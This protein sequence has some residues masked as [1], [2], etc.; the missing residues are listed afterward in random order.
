MNYKSRTK[1]ARFSFCNTHHLCTVS[2]LFQLLF[3]DFDIFFLSGDCIF[4]FRHNF[5]SVW[6][7][8]LRVVRGTTAGRVAH[9]LRQ[10]SGQIKKQYR[11]LESSAADSLTN[12]PVQIDN[13][14]GV[15]NVAPLSNDY[16]ASR[17][18]SKLRNVFPL[19]LFR[20]DLDLDPVAHS[21]PV[22]H[23]HSDFWVCVTKWLSKQMFLSSDDSSRA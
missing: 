22:T 17:A 10:I 12:T 19:F 20:G 4:R 15:V 5:V 18:V 13:F 6:S 16:C 1:T 8:F 7:V 23:L 21:K 14:A 11:L 2:Q 9:G 3:N